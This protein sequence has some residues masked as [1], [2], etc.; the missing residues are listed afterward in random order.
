MLQ[1]DEPQLVETRSS[2]SQFEGLLSVRRGDEWVPIVF[3]AFDGIVCKGVR[4]HKVALS[5]KP[6]IGYVFPVGERREVEQAYLVSDQ[7]GIELKPLPHFYGAG[8]YEQKYD[9]EV[10]V[11]ADNGALGVVNDTTL[12]VGL[13]YTLAKSHLEDEDENWGLTK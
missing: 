2:I 8:F 12:R 9:R 13:D 7:S 10:L 5:V 6:Y 1:P 11:N 4:S 3:D